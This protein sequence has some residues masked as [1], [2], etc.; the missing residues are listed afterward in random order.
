MKIRNL[1]TSTLNENLTNEIL[2]KKFCHLFSFCLFNHF[3]IFYYFEHCYSFVIQMR[4]ICF[5]L[6]SLVWCDCVMY[7]VYV[8]AICQSLSLSALYSVESLTQ[9]WIFDNN[10]EALIPGSRS[11]F[12]KYPF[13][14]RMTN[15]CSKI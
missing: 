6:F 13:V 5:V 2:N 15:D 7:M 8:N 1:I 3:C 11:P 14:E 9:Y 12:L 4:F 10:A